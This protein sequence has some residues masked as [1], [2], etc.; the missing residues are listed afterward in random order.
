MGR[1]G[2]VEVGK[3]EDGSVVRPKKQV[4]KQR[5]V[6][7]H[8]RFPHRSMMNPRKGERT[9]GTTKFTLE[10]QPAAAASLPKLVESKSLEKKKCLFTICLACLEGG[11]REG[12][13]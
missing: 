8:E 2:R 9:T 4:E 6:L 12:K 1:N 7:I 5:N 10:S 3:C 13:D 11:E